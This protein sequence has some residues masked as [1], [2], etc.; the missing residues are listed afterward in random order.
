MPETWKHPSIG[1]FKREDYGWLCE[2]PSIWPGVFPHC[3]EKTTPL[4]IEFLES[5]ESKPEAE[6]VEQLGAFWAARSGVPE[7]VCERLWSEIQ[8][9]TAGDNWWSWTDQD[10]FE[11][12]IENYGVSA[13]DSEQDFYEHLAI[14]VVT[15]RHFP[16]EGGEP[17][18]VNPF[19]GEEIERPKPPP[20]ARPAFW[21]VE[22]SFRCLWE[23]E[24]GIAAFWRNGE[25]I[26]TCYGDGQGAPPDD[27]A[28]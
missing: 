24:H 14:P 21:A 5:T 27:Y 19:T 25:V 15:V 11:R 26:G 18:T 28:L 23:E 9:E 16:E 1:D 7:A 4:G 12:L 6:A 20:P 3:D 2:V 22:C 8:G 17:M 13:P 10:E